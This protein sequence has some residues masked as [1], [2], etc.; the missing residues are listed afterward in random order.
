[1]LK[2]QSGDSHNLWTLLLFNHIYVHI[3]YLQDAEKKA[4]EERIRME[5]IIKGNPLINQDKMAEFKVKRRWTIAVSDVLI[6]S[7]QY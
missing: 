4:E 6:N 3:L 1:M 2:Y 7:F 5:N